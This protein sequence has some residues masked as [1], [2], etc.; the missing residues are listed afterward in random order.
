MKRTH[1]LNGE[2][3]RLVFDRRLRIFLRIHEWREENKR[4]SLKPTISDSWTPEQR[5]TCLRDWLDDSDVMEAVRAEKRTHDEMMNEEPSTS[6]QVNEEVLQISRGKVDDNERPF[7]IESYSQIITG[8]AMK[9]VQGRRADMFSASPSKI[10][11]ES[12]TNFVYNDLPTTYNVNPTNEI[13]K[14]SNLSTKSNNNMANTNVDQPSVVNGLTFDGFT[15]CWLGNFTDLKSY[16]E[17]G[18]KLAGKWTSPGGETK[19]FTASQDE[20]VLKWLKSKKLIIQKDNPD[21][22]LLKSFESDH[23]L[24]NSDCDLDCNVSQIDLQIKNIEDKLFNAI[25]TISK[26]LN[27]LKSQCKNNCTDTAYMCFLWDENEKLKKQNE[28]L[29]EKLNNCLLA[30]SELNIRVKDLQNEKDSLITA[31]KVLHYDNVMR[32]CKQAVD[33]AEVIQTSK[34]C[35]CNV[36]SSDQATASDNTVKV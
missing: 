10:L 29:T 31:I 7:Y 21:E 19:L 24:S 25:D 1:F 20:F 15:Y 26:E 33:K 14:G 8:T 17:Q 12:L 28:L 6:H 35:Q 9:A 34:A 27:D 36:A 5:E 4:L 13:E 32:P 23:K 2:E 3:R 16:V 18:L 22:Y 30:G 11:A